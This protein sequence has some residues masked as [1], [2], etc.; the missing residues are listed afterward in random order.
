M[1]RFDEDERRE[2]LDLGIGVYRDEDGRTPIMAAVRAA[3][4]ILLETRTTKTYL[5]SSGDE[6]FLALLADLALGGPLAS[7]DRLVGVQTPGGS[8][9]LRLGAEL[10]ARASPGASVWIGDPTWPN[11]IPILQQAGLRVRTHR[12]LDRG[13]SRIDFAGMIEDLSEAAPGD[14]LLLHGCCHNPTGTT[15]DGGQWHRIAKLCVDVALLP[16][17]DLAYQGF[18]EALD[19]DVAPTRRLLRQ[20]P[21]ALVAYSCSKTFGLYRERTGALWM[22]GE[23]RSVAEIGLDHLRALARSLWS[24][25]PDHGAAVV[26]TI[27]ERRD[28]QADWEVELGRMRSRIAVLRQALAAA[29]PAL[30]PIA[31][32]QGMFALLPLDPTQIAEL[33]DRNGFYLMANGRINLC[34]LPL[35]R[36]PAFQNAIAPY[37]G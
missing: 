7:S 1:R 34:G 11:H 22:Q 6:H 27:L 8:G 5:G 12:L 37:L 26:R 4:A 23:S 10:I 17:I 32:Q 36:M 3:E 15:F 25:P 14:V 33:R 35:R 19:A 31:D 9:A 13:A 30:A 29:H 21:S 28:L 20:V 2:K 18:G 16:F 24:M